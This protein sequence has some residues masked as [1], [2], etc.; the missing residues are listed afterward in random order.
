M[1]FLSPLF[2][3]LSNYFFFFLTEKN[4]LMHKTLFSPFHL[5]EI[6]LNKVSSKQALYMSN[7]FC[8]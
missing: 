4:V 3:K 1:A 6:E 5:F 8:P 2:L 7:A